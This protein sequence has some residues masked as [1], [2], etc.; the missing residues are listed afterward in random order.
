MSLISPKG[1]FVLIKELIKV[2]RKDNFL[3]FVVCITFAL[4]LFFLAIWWF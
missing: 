4:L 3:F 2:I 1:Y